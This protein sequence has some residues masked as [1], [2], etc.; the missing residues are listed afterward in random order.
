MKILA[1]PNLPA[2]NITLTGVV[3]YRSKVVFP[4]RDHNKKHGM[5]S[6]K[7]ILFEQCLR[8]HGINEY[9]LADYLL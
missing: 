5:C 4:S 2:T 1:G 8:Q 7:N 9:A 6:G 3:L